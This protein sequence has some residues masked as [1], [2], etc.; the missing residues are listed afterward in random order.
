MA[1]V[2]SFVPVAMSAR[3][4]RRSMY[5]LFLHIAKGLVFTGSKFK[6]QGFGLYMSNGHINHGYQGTSMPSE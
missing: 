5:A 1:G 6:V 4:L 3:A 2:I